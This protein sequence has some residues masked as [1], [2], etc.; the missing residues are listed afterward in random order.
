MAEQILL[1]LPKDTL[2]LACKSKAL[3]NLGQWDSS[4]LDT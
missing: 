3:L 1:K 2:A 4:Q